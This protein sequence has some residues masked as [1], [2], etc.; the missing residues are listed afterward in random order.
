[1]VATTSSWPLSGTNLII[2]GDG[3]DTITGGAGTDT[4]YGGLGDNVLSTGGGADKVY[5]D[6]AGLAFSLSLTGVLTTTAAAASSSVSNDRNII[7]GG[8]GADSL[9]GGAGNDTIIGGSGTKLIVGG[10]GQTNIQGGSGTGVSITG[11]NGGDTIIGSDGGGDII[12]G[13]SGA[14]RIEL[15]GSGNF[16]NGGAGDDVIVGG[17]GNDILEGGPGNDLLTSASAT[18]TLY[19]YAANAAGDDHATDRLF[20]LS[21]ASG[22]SLSSPTAAVSLTSVALPSDPVPQGWWSAIAGPAGI[23][24]G[25]IA[26][27]ASSPAIA[28]DASGPWLAW[29]QSNN[30]VVG[31]YVAHDVGGTW[32]AVA[33]SATG[34]GLTPQARR[35]P[36]PP[37]PSSVASRW[38]HGRRSPRRAPASRPRLTIRAPMAVPAPGLHWAAPCRPPGSVASARSTMRRVLVTA[39]GPVV[40]WRDMS[41]A[42]PHLFARRFDGANWVELGTG[43]ASGNGVAGTLAVP[44]DYTVATDGTRVALAFSVT[45]SIGSALQVFEYS[46]ASWQALASPN[47]AD[48][49]TNSSSS[50]SPGLAYSGGKLFIA[51]TQH[52]QSTGYLSRIFVKS[53][54]AGV[55]TAAGAGAAS[56]TGIA[57]GDAMA[58]QPILAASGSALR[59]VWSATVDVASGESHYLRSLSWNGTAF[60]ADK[61]SDISGTGIGQL[62]GLARTAALALDSS[63]R[64]YLAT[65]TTGSGGLTVRAGLT[66]AAHVFVADAQTS[67][68]SIL[69]GGAIKSG[70]LILVTA[71]TADTDL[72]LGAA[73]LGITIAGKDGVVFAHGIAVNGATGVTIRDL[74][75]TGPVS[76]T[77]TAQVKLAENTFR[78]TVTLNQ[79]TA[80]VMRDNR[81]VAASVGL[82]ISGASQG[83]IYDNSFAGSA[84]ALSINASFAGLISANDISAIGTAVAYSAGAAL[85][86]NRIHGATIGVASPVQDANALFGAFAGSGSNDIFQNATGVALTGAQVIGQHIFANA[87]GI[88]GSGTIGG[89]VPAS[90]NLINYNQTGIS[91]FTGLVRFDRIE[92][93]GIGIAASNGL[94]IF[95]SQFIANTGAAI[96]V[97]GV[98][99]VEIAGNTIHAAIGDGVRLVNA[100]FNVE[101]ISNIIWTDGGIGI[102]VANNSQAGFWSDY[103]TLFATGNGQ[104]VY[105]TKGFK[106]ILD[107]QDDV[108]RFDLHSDGVTVVNPG[109]AEPHFAADALGFMTTR[110]VVA[111]QRLSDPTADGGDPTGTFIGYTGVANLLGN[112]DF[113]NGLSGWTV[114]AGGTTVTTGLAAWSG[115]ATFQSGPSANSV[116]QQTV[117]LVATGYSTSQIDS[118]SLKLAFGGRVSPLT[119]SVSAQISIV[120]RD[121]AN[122]PVGDAIVVPAGTDLGRWL[123]VFSTVYIP[124]GARYAQFLF[125]V[126]KSDGSQGALLDAAY[127]AVVPRGAGVDQGV[128]TAADNLP[129]DPTLGRIALRSP[130]LYVDLTVNKPLFITWDS[131]GAAANNPVKI[132]L[133]Q[134]GTNGPQFLATI[135]ASAPDTG[136]YAWTP[137]DSALVAGTHG[138]RIQISSVAHPQIYDRSAETFTVPEAGTNYYV[139]AS[140]GSNRN[141]G[142]VAAAP[143]AS[144]VNL[145]RTYDV[146]AGAIVNIAAG[147]YALID[148]LQ[149]SGTTDHG[150]GLDTGFTV[151]G[152]SNGITRLFP[153]IPGSNPQALIDL[154]GASFVSLNHLT[155]Q[156]GVD[157]VRVG[158]GS[159]NFN[160]SYLTASGTS[161]DAFNITTNSPTGVLDHLTATGAG[162]AGLNLTGTIATISFFTATGDHDGI[163]ATGSIGALTDSVISG[164]ATYGYGLYLNLTGPSLIEANTISGNYVGAQLFGSGIIFGNA[165]LSKGRGNNVFGNTY[166]AI[167]ARGAT[168]VGNSIHNNTGYYDSVFISQGASFRYNLLYANNNG[169]DDAS[170]AD[171][172]GN[173]IF[174]N[175]GYGLLLDAGNV[176]VSQN[177][178][179]SNGVSLQAGSSGE[180]I[181]NNLIY[182]DT[183]AGIRLYNSANVTIRNNTIYEPTAGTVSDASNPNY[184]S[185]AIALD[186]TSSG[187]TIANNII[188]ALAGVGIRVSD[189]SQAGFVSD[190]N[191]FQTGAGGRVGSWLGVDR[192][193][194]NQWRS[195]TSRDARSRT[196]DPLFVSPTGADGKLGYVSIAANGSDDDFHVQSAQGSYHAGS[197]SAVVGSNGLPQLTSAQLTV[198]AQTSPAI[199]SG[200]PATPIG[201]E[202]APNGGIVEVGTY[203]GTAQASLSPSTFITV[204]APAGGDTL[205][206]GTTVQITWNSF[207][208]N[209]NVDVSVSSDGVH[210][211]TLAAGIA[212]TGSYAWTI[213]AATFAPASTYVVKVASSTTPSVFDVSDGTFSIAG[214]VHV[215]YINDNSTVADQYTT[216]IGDDVANDG[217]SADRPMATLS[218]LLARY[219]LGAGDVVE[220]DTGVYKLT[221]NVVFTSADSGVG[222][223]TSQRVTIQGPTNGGVATFDRQSKSAGFYAFE[224]NG[225]D[226]VTL[227]NLRIIG[228]AAGVFADDNSASKGLTVASSVVDGN[229]IDIYIGTGDDNFTL[230]AS[231]ISNGQ[232]SGVQISNAANAQILNSLITIPVTGSFSYGVFLNTA[233]NA[234]VRNDTFDGGNSYAPRLLEVDFSNNVLVDHVTMAHSNYYNIYLYRSNGIVQNSTIDATGGSFGIEINGYQGTSY[235]VGNTVYGENGGNSYEGAIVVDDGGY[236]SNNV[237]Y[238]SNI[239]FR[240][241]GTGIVDNNRVYGSQIG[242]YD[243]GSTVRNNKVY[244]NVTGIIA[245]GSNNNILNNFIYDNTTAGLQVGLYYSSPQGNEILN[246]TI[247]QTQ[248]TALNLRTNTNNTDFRDNIISLQN[249]VGIVGPASAQAG[250]RSD[251]NLWDLRAGATLATWSGQTVSTLRDWKTKIGFDYNSIGGDPAFINAAGADGVRGAVGGVDYGADDNVSLQTTSPALNRGDLVQAYFKE[252]AGQGSGNGDRVDIGA[253]GGTSAANAGPAQLVQVL[254]STGDQRYQV[255]QPA[256]ISFRS[257]GLTAAD[258]VL[259]IDAVGGAVQGSESWNVWQANSFTSI[260]A[261]STY[262]ATTPINANALDIPAAVLNNMQVFYASNNPVTKYN[263]PLTDGT[264]HVTLVFADNQSTAIGQRVFDILGNGVTYGAAFDAFKSAGGANKATTFSF[265]ITTTGGAGLALGLKEIAGSAILNGIQISRKTAV[266]SVWTASADVSYDNGQTWTNIASGL[267]LDQFGAGS[268][269]FNPAATTSGFSGLLRVTATDGVHT[270]TDQSQGGFMVA[271][272]GNAYYVNDGSTSG[273]VYTTAAGNDNNTGKTPDNPMASLAALLNVY[274]LQP[275]DVVYVDSGTYTLPTEISFGASES[276]TWPVRSASSAPARPPFSIAARRLQMHRCS[277]LPAATTSRSRTWC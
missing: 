90:V 89:A 66:S 49:P 141:D 220:V 239:G 63:G 190:Y 262:S 142:K 67:I 180:V 70:D 13:G 21:T 65:D 182:G 135:A 98:G 266:A 72:T 3:N 42:T 136:R 267:A 61:P 276:G 199:D 197:L 76:V 64:P 191:L 201:A 75:I 44:S 255:G 274:K 38:W 213:D 156:G 6:N 159:D 144:P 162:G 264:Y 259:F 228:G 69:S 206:Q 250:F 242:I 96:Q 59:L 107:W 123:R 165:D 164:S 208:I 155:L 214:P 211:T 260:S 134:D 143:K 252:P 196:G 247:V 168:I 253:T 275:G 51:W 60:V 119:S 8:S 108:A 265:D 248:G 222:D 99:N 186:R 150:F 18:D 4:I 19:G 271:P 74:D 273:D 157:A 269:T 71:T 133:W 101:L 113:E 172:V 109:W 58:G 130:D 88:S 181:T 254:G 12:Q 111:G 73:A 50:T 124:A 207:N 249:A 52:D 217:K 167:N 212:N 34:D 251:Y 47:A 245:E 195:A 91:G 11:G 169:L 194:L 86:G 22:D 189:A 45:T 188:V 10:R 79:A 200:N 129:G 193:S 128:R 106:D 53:E 117:D 177:T 81:F 205:T 204:T 16:V 140:S 210:F 209:G 234:V 277:G 27:N 146:G 5:G 85:Y 154:T 110:P 93:N 82:A 57:P 131:Y 173:R 68:A 26:G 270:V 83:A 236:A 240:V 261:Y 231:T 263:V 132:E 9:Y 243:V 268:F 43:S 94:R 148:A 120:F 80:I 187:A 2:G 160:A 20:P 218:A 184:G 97:S 232:S 40:V 100:A 14:D 175:T 238:N 163:I 78:S 233:N 272:A 216:A 198:D 235:A 179:Y 77:N 246:N 48:T 221:N 55:W 37:S 126:S 122:N 112:G 227:A 103:N 166:E 36:I 256:T 121:A 84:T 137:S 202:T 244:D 149:L 237:V 31:L 87:I 105:W 28:A 17:A 219:V 62:S 92:D 158:A 161:G 151:N 170:V 215:Y 147:D 33:G 102:N 229:T 139:D 138:L 174:G 226:F 183:Y 225:A 152:S 224:F 178:L 30:G 95:N 29:T 115:A 114:T 32:Q 153:A 23:S 241:S 257:A 258:P 185:A 192:S 145:F 223:L 176:T 56:G 46:G 203:G 41:G 118:G 39:S 230:T 25:G 171:V 24:L 15:R 54:S 35:P 7:N 127:L 125:G 116:A 1:M 104:I